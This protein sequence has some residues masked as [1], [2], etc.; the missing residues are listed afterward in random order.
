MKNPCRQDFSIKSQACEATQVI[1]QI[2]H[3]TICMM[4]HHFKYAPEKQMCRNN[5]LQRHWLL[6]NRSHL[7]G[8][9]SSSWGATT[10]EKFWP[11]QWVSS[12]WSGFWCSPSSLLFSSLLFRSLHH[13]PIYFQ[14]FLAILL[15]RVTTH[16]LF[17]PCCYLAYDVRV[18]TKLIFVLWCSLWCFYY[19]SVCLVLH[20]I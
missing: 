12:I 16:I 13:T 4:L 9:S 8:S 3:P 10:S 15:V 17:L 5:S 19:Q 1:Q 18:W 6:R 11:S 7:E 14:V 20:S 2:M